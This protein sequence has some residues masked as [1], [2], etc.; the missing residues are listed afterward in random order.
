MGMDIVITTEAAITPVK[1]N[2]IPIRK[3]EWL[4]KLV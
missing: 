3:E 2:R 1:S 4:L